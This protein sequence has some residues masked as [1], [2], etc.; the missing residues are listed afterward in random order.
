MA[1]RIVHVDTPLS[2]LATAYRN[3]AYIAERAV[4]TVPVQKQS[5]KYFTFPKGAIFRDEAALIAGG[6]ESPR[7]DF[8]ISTDTFFCNPYGFAHNILDDDRENADAP[9]NIEADGVEYC[10]GKIL[11][12]KE[13]KVATKLLTVATWAS[14]STMDCEG[15]WVAGESNTFI[16]DVE[17][18]I[19]YILSHTGLRPNIMIMDGE[20]LSQVKQ[21]STVLER[22]KY[23][24]RGIVSAPLIAALFD[25]DEV[26]IGDALTSTAVEKADGTDFTGKKIWELN[27][28]KGSA[29]L[30][31]R[32]PAAGIKVPSPAYLFSWGRNGLTR[33]V[34]RWREDK[35][36][37]DV[38]EAVERYD[39]KIT[40]SDLGFLL[41]DTLST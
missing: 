40:G 41:Y 26:L 35:N 16:A 31:Y 36:H 39:I 32:P 15:T 20:T 21:E 11:L 17:Y 25:L 28:A 22:I 8:P 1:P 27:A 6:A 34:N 12:G 3:A 13:N 30:L 19:N 37:R 38:V 10:T 9:L 2:N 29:L 33:V 24:E 7:G 5:D 18:G 23:V 14:G 4:R